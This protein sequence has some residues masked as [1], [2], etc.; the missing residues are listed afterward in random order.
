MVRSRFHL[1]LLQ[2]FVSAFGACRGSPSRPRARR[3]TP[4]PIP[5]QAELHCNPGADRDHIRGRRRRA[6]DLLQ[7]AV[8]RWRQWPPARSRK[9]RH[10]ITCAD[11][12]PR[13][14]TLPPRP[15][16]TARWAWSDVHRSPHPSGLRRPLCHSVC[17]S[18][19]TSPG[20]RSGRRCGD[21]GHADLVRTVDHRYGRRRPLHPPHRRIGVL[22]QE[23]ACGKVARCTC[24]RRGSG[25]VQTPR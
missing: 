19:A 8:H 24:G 1:H 21:T 17:R 10:K 22:A 25:A 2:Y 18:V 4:E 12:T 7:L 20:R 5:N 23:Q 16:G 3:R 15:A 9:E 11:V 14:L 13:H 6:P